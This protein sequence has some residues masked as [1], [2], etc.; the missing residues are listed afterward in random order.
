MEE[1][2]RERRQEARGE[3]EERRIFGEA[4]ARPVAVVCS[5][6]P[7]VKRDINTLGV[8]IIRGIG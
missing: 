2:G 1:D 6:R 5:V 8:F 3:K 4:R 7:K